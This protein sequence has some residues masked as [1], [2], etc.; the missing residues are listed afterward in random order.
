MV[1]VFVAG[2]LFFSE[3]VP[4]ETG[5][6]APAPAVAAKDPELLVAMALV[7][8]A[9]TVAEQQMLAAQAAERRARRGSQ[10]RLQSGMPY[11]SFGATRRGES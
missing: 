6:Y 7:R 5:P 3:P 11:Y 9:L 2:G 4:A 10:L 8:S 1:A